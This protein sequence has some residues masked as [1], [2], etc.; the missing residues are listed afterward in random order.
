MHKTI[1]NKIIFMFIMIFIAWISFIP[2]SLQIRYV[3]SVQSILVAMV[4]LSLY[5]H[6]FNLSKY[7]I[8]QNALFWVYI[9]LFSINIWFA[10]D[11][12]LSRGYY[13]GFI[14]IAIPIYFI[15]QHQLDK[16]KTRRI[17]YFLCICAGLVALFGFM[18]MI[19]KHNFLYENIVSNVFYERFILINKRMM[20]TLMHPNVL[21]SY[22]L[23]CLPIAY[24]F[25]VSEK[26]GSIKNV[27]FATFLLIFSAIGLTFSRG[28]WISLILML[29]VWMA[30][31]RKF[32]W[33]VLVWSL[34][35]LFIWFSSS[36]FCFIPGFRHRFRIELLRHYIKYAHRTGAYLV[37]WSMLKEHPFVGIGL[38][39][40]R[41]LFNLYSNTKRSYEVMIPDSV[42]LM[43]LAETGII[44]FA[45]F[46]A[47]LGS[48]FRKL[49]I[50]Y[51]KSEENSKKL[52]FYMSISF[53]GLLF[54]M[55]TYDVFLWKT[56]LYLFWLFCGILMSF[57][58]E[59][60]ARL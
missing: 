12:D 3:G 37:T 13:R 46:I 27:N 20:S 43:H 40:F 4:I 25:Y 33:I 9:F 8:L 30:L 32:K 19:F 28:T 59:E 55:N 18:E 50:S 17:L 58:M 47:F 2:E 6:K 1:L 57:S 23:A 60:Q 54:N 15:L 22:L 39:H 52:I 45:G 10:K 24:Y 48:I 29:T 42:Y 44:G 34:A 41:V 38:G 11:L 5:L 49:F 56:P 16:N 7:F 31:K 35:V 21:S 26:R 53:I 14:L 36:R 51:G